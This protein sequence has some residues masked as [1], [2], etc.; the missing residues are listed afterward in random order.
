MHDAER[1]RFRLTC[2]SSWLGLGVTLISFTTMLLG[3]LMVSRDMS[4]L[5]SISAGLALF[6]CGAS[7][8]YAGRISAAAS[9]VFRQNLALGAVILA[10]GTLVFYAALGV[11]ESAAHASWLLA[12]MAAVVLTFVAVAT[13]LTHR[14]QWPEFSQSLAA[15]GLMLSVL[16]LIGYL[17][18]TLVLIELGTAF[19]MSLPAALMTSVLC[20]SLLFTRP[21]VGSMAVATSATPAGD[22]ARRLMFP[23][24]F[25]P[26]LFNFLF[27]RL[28]QWGWVTPGF[29]HALITFAIMVTIA[30][31]V[32][33]QVM[34]L[35]NTHGK[36]QRIEAGA[37]RL[38][39]RY[40]LA[41]EAGNIG[42]WDINLAT[43]Q[44]NATGP[45]YEKL[46]TQATG[47][48]YLSDWQALSHPQD[49]RLVE[50]AFERVGRDGS[51]Q[52]E[53]EHRLRN[54][55]GDWHWLFSR[56]SVSARDSD[57]KPLHV[58]G[59]DVDIHPLKV[60]QET[61]R[62]SQL[63]MELAMKS[64]SFFLW[65]FHVQEQRLVDMEGLIRS[66]GY[67]PS[68]DTEKVAFWRSLLHPDD[69]A[70][71]QGEPLLPLPRLVQEKGVELQVRASDGNWRW[72]VVR[73]H[74]LDSSPQGRPEVITGT[75][76]DIT[77]RKQEAEKLLHVAQH[78]ALTGLPNRTLT[79]AFAGRTLVSCHRHAQQCALLF[80]DLDR[81]K[82]INDSF[83]HAAGDAVLQEVAK[84]L[85]RCVRAEDVVGR[86]GGDEFLVVLAE[87]GAK[88]AVSHIANTIIAC[89]SEPIY[90]Q[91]SE[92]QVSSS[93][94]ISRYPDDARE[95]ETLVKYADTAMYHAKQDGRN[96]ARFFTQAMNRQAKDLLKCEHRMRKAVD[97]RGFRLVYQPVVDTETHRVVAA[98]AL[99]RWPG[100]GLDPDTF[101]PLAESSGL[102]L[103]LGE[104][105]LQ[106]ACRQQQRW[107]AEGMGNIQMAVNVSPIQFRQHDFQQQ[108]VDSITQ[109]NMDPAQLQLE[110]TENAFMQDMHE[111]SQTL[112]ALRTMGLTIALDDFGKG[113]SSLSYLKNLPLD[114]VKVDKKFVLNLQSDPANLSITE[115]IINLTEGLGLQVT[116][117]GVENE[118]VLQLLRA[119]RYRHMQGFHLCPPLPAASFAAWYWDPQ[120]LQSVSRH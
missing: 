103:P 18:N 33:W 27:Y 95:L 69:S 86:L 106:E 19:P 36:Q 46:F 53:L 45:M 110:I 40:N 16:V 21:G 44:I 98:E 65:H 41:M 55:S 120:S 51:D 111:V 119:M 47:V 20:L 80:I 24:I 10:V 64:A 9:S 6:L 93:M 23:L 105:V 73:A 22:V 58:H 108:V 54:R 61:L 29:E 13:W 7:L 35:Y 99:L 30:T 14:N 83:G 70:L 59:V 118:A 15:A 62:K 92:L 87:T 85:R 96:N 26:V 79:T 100:E 4:F 102:I 48:M 49:K 74:V 56:A 114:R 113:Y 90:Y 34:T 82:P 78:D 17:E 94:G 116:A 88:E 112:E 5:P 38:Q 107:V 2:Y 72:L 43:R 91:E 39:E 75:C 76:V 77:T 50:Q 12:P 52:I 66:L 42:V 109:A 8:T 63:D 67:Q 117:E 71:W 3:L 60:F 57:G 101:I 11:P 97:N 25:M 89:L 68:A 84:R 32:W 37:R 115:A 28:G 1:L 31:L 81:F 104:W